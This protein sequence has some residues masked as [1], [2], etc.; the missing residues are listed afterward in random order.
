MSKDHVGVV[1]LVAEGSS[2]IAVAGMAPR[3]VLWGKVGSSMSGRVAA[4]I[5]ADNLGAVA[6]NGLSRMKT[7]WRSLQGSR[8]GKLVTRSLW[9]LALD[10]CEY[11]ILAR[12][13]DPVFESD[14]VC[15]CSR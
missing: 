8:G 9:R 13:R 12:N 10:V 4:V 6:P 11:L 14:V 3:L 7:F 15:G 5:A 2:L 1:L